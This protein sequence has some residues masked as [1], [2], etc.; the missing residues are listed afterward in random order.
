MPP[1]GRAL[2]AFASSSHKVS[3]AVA[4]Q[5]PR[6]SGPSWRG[7]TR[8]REAA[9]LGSGPLRARCWR[10]TALRFPKSSSLC[11]RS[12]ANLL[13]SCAASGAPSGRAR[14]C[15]HRAGK[16][17]EQAYQRVCTLITLG[18]NALGPPL[19]VLKDRSAGCGGRHFRR[20]VCVASLARIR[21]RKL[22]KSY[23]GASESAGR[24]QVRCECRTPLPAASREPVSRESTDTCPSHK[25]PQDISDIPCAQLTQ[26]RKEEEGGDVYFQ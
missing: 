18:T 3:R 9:K 20:G 16:P 14:A 15:H 22:L 17:R 21:S 7:T 12:V 1:R 4:A 26:G 19:R 6:S 8:S 11:Q 23:L 10:P 25:N 5:E 13:W 24:G 2:W